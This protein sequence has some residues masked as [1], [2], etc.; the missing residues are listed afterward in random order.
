MKERIRKRRKR[1]NI[2][3]EREVYIY[4]EGKKKKHKR[5]NRTIRSVGMAIL[6]IRLDRFR[7]FEYSRALL[8]ILVRSRIRE[9]V[10]N[11]VELIAGGLEPK[12]E[13]NK[14]KQRK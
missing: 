3:R 7:T 9:L 5:L 10:F 8:G 14:T 11:C 12:K 2:Y 13:K 4:K 1:R 6:M